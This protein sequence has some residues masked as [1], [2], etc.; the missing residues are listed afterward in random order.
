M[1]ANPRAL[2]NPLGLPDLVSGSRGIGWW[3]VL[4]IVVIESTVFSA[5]IA[6]YFYLFAG[7]TEW[8][9]GG[10][11]PPE[12]L[13]PTV[14]AFIL[15][16][17]VIPMYWGDRAIRSGNLNALRIGHAIGSVMLVTFILLKWVEYNGLSYDWGTN[18]YGSIVWTTTGFHVAH[19][20][21]VLL[22]TLSVQV[23]AWKGFWNEHRHLT[24]QTTSLYWFFVAAVWIPLFATLYLFPN[25]A[26]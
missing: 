9:L 19:V 13:L 12:L 17:S 25:F 20:I 6:S 15:F 10:F 1:N 22:K 11:D 3:G 18:A 16:A 5:L 7:S 2:E 26:V 8:P 23:L 14:N 4:F 24:V 21:A